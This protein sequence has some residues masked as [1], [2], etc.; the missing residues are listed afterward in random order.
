MR[1][2]L[3]EIGT[4]EIPAGWL[5]P[6]GNQLKDLI[7]EL[8]KTNE[9]SYKKIKRFYTPRRII[10][11]IK[12]VQEKQKDKIVEI[13]GPPKELAFD[14][15]GNLTKS[16]L[17]FAKAHKVR[18]SELKIKKKGGK[19]VLYCQK[20]EKGKKTI[21]ILKSSLPNI[22]NSIEFPKS[23]HWEG[24]GFRFARP[25]RWITALFDE[26]IIKFEIAGVK[27]GNKT[28]GLRFIP[29]RLDSPALARRDRQARQ[30]I[31]LK[32]ASS[33]EEVMKENNILVAPEERLSSIIKSIKKI[34][35]EKKLLFEYD[36]TLAKEVTNLVECP[37]AI[38]GKFPQKY[39]KLPQEVIV[40]ALRSHQRYFGLKNKDRTLSPYFIAI[41]N[42]KEGNIDEI[43]EGNERVLRARLE[44][45]EFYYKEDMKIKLAQRINELKGV[46]WQDRIGTLYDK[47]E[48]LIKLSE[49]IAKN[50]IPE[51][52][53]NALKLA[54]KLSKVDL[55]TNMIKDGKEFTKLEGLYGGILAKKQGINSK[56][57]LA[58]KE[59]YLIPNFS[60]SPE[61]VVLAIADRIDTI[62]GAFILGKIPTGSK[63]PLGIRKAGNEF[64]AIIIKNNIHI[65]L[66]QL[67]LKA[68]E[69]YKEV[70][71]EKCKVQIFEFLIQRLRKH[72]E[73]EGIR[74]D[75]I[76]AVIPARLMAG[77]NIP[78]E[79][80]MD[81]MMRAKVL[82][83]LREKAKFVELATLAK[84][85]RNI[86][87]SA[88]SKSVSPVSPSQGGQYAPTSIKLELL[89][90][91]EERELYDALIAGQNEFKNYLSKRDYINALNW[92]L[93]LAP[94][95][96]NLFDKVLIM[97][98]D[99]DLCQNRLALVDYLSS[100]F[101][102]VA[103]FSKIAV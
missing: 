50:Y 74:Y 9:I 58:I 7:C 60:T 23:M 86:L 13:T 4:E 82:D 88:N 8:L 96:N 89:K 55:L 48:R 29:P 99:P 21:D 38:L 22:I 76:E 36:T 46:V 83:N 102:K 71:N 75:I 63:D 28:Q 85:T 80:M 53:L 68:L 47:T 51:I 54:A 14:A 27:S 30:A 97:A 87:K 59:Q 77:G 81:L 90:E 6:A 72:S 49:Y 92:L 34:T 100:F 11:L 19:E 84:R 18:P 61:G 103:D 17:G 101:Q 40:A 70:Q 69:I 15:N 57:A 73:G 43:R 95:I 94:L 91:N 3:L 25:I 35:Q 5:E 44:D 42:T 52:D 41:A 26:D 39:L 37:R 24:T 66:K 33:Y 1:D 78:N 32:I 93:N 79:D 2:F 67:I 31:D 20:V 56:V 65:Q 12:D 10:L 45:A 62:T 16:A 98:P 64:I